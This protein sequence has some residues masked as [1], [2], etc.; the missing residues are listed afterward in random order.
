MAG[1]IL[2]PVCGTDL[3]GWLNRPVVVSRFG[4]TERRS[5]R[6]SGT[7]SCPTIC[8]CLSRFRLRPGL[9]A[10][11]FLAAIGL[12]SSSLG[13]MDADDGLKPAAPGLGTKFH[14]FPGL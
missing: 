5:V 8:R 12:L 10:P 1:R 11:R 2:G 9:L 14:P 4:S 6:V 3:N 7:C 13:A